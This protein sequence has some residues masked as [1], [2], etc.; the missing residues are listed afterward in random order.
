VALRFED[1]GEEEVDLEGRAAVVTPDGR[2]QGEVQAVRHV[3]VPPEEELLGETDQETP[4]VFFF[5]G[6]EIGIIGVGGVAQ[7]IKVV[8]GV[9]VLEEGEASGV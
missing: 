3:E 2:P 9:V 1:V 7:G 8:C 5:Q 6:G 4:L